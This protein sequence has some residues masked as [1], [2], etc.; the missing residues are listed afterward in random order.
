M[1]YS[2][3]ILAIYTEWNN[4]PDRN[5]QNAY[6]GT[7]YYRIVKPMQALKDNFDIDI[8][9]KEITYQFGKTP[10]EIWTNIFK[11]YDIVYPRHTDNPTAINAMLALAK[12]FG[13]KVMMDMDD[14]YLGVLPH[15]PAY[16]YYHPGSQKVTVLG[17]TMSLLDGITVSTDPLKKEYF[18]HTKKIHN[19]EPQIDVLPNCNDFRDWMYKKKVHNDG[20][21]RIGYAG[22]TTH[23]GDLEIAIPAIKRI[24]KQHNAR[25]QILG[26]ISREYREEFLN[27]FGEV[28][29][30]VDIFYG[31]PTWNGY[32]ELLLSQGWDIGIAPLE[33]N[34]F[35]ICKSHIK[36][37][38]YAMA[39]IP[40]VAS[41]VYPYY[42]TIQGV[43]TI[44][45]G[46]TGFLAKT[47]EDWFNQLEELIKRK[48]L[49]RKIATN[50]Y[51]FIKDNWQW[52]QHK[53]KWV[54]TFKKYL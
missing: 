52:E 21:I 49:R 29:D 18:D 13:K 54:N 11:K 44:R 43:D 42:Q 36:W 16:E 7:G 33:D 34:N 53:H 46:E 5:N 25:F 47:E 14:N 40:T 6:G 39:G 35:T 28:K 2:N 30:K 48:N 38:E 31:T 15:Q 51:E 24:L 23:N 3:K 41:Y 8:V 9:G 37:M 19:V 10:E 20:I 17:A 12:H 45:H 32:P 50:A 4:N 1:A 26:S 22:S 27:K